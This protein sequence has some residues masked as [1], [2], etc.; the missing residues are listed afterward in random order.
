MVLL[1]MPGL[2]MGRDRELRLIVVREVAW[3]GLAEALIRYAAS[4]VVRSRRSSLLLAWAR[5]EQAWAPF[6]LSAL[7]Q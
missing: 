2:G 1:M 4:A 3:V 6:L 7:R 5:L